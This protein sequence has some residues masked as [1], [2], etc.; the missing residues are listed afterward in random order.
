MF[1]EKITNA[2]TH[3]SQCMTICVPGKGFKLDNGGSR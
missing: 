2:N 3:E 1:Y